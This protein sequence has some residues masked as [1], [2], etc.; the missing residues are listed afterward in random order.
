MLYDAQPRRLYAIIL[1]RDYR[2]TVHSRMKR[3]RDLETSV[4]TWARCMRQIEE[5]TKDIPA[6][7]RIRVRYEDLCA[8]PRAELSRICDFLKLDF[9]EKMLS[10]PAG[11]VHHI[12]GSPSKFDPGRRKIELDQSYLNAFTAEQ[13]A[14]MKEIAGEAA[15]NWGYA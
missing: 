13:L 6:Q 9:S 11:N 4:R 8:D 2:G 3:G 15:V 14:T 10:R 12:G 1:G 7:Q 5:L